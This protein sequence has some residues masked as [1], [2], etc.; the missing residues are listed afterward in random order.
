MK[1][2][3]K[4]SKKTITSLHC[5]LLLSLLAGTSPVLAQTASIQPIYAPGA[6]FSVTALNDHG[7]VAGY[8]FESESVQ[9]AFI[10]R[11]GLAADIGTLGGSFSLAR[12]LNNSGAVVGFSSLSSESVFR[13]FVTSGNQMFDA[14]SLGGTFSAAMAISDAGH[15]VGDSNVPEDGSVFRAFLV[16][17]SGSVVD[18]GTLGGSWST[19]V[20]VNSSGAVAGYSVLPGDTAMHAYLYNGQTTVDLGTLGGASS[21]AVDVN[22]TGQVA[23]NSTT[24]AESTHA[25]LFA[26]GDM[27]DLGTLGGSGSS[28]VGLNDS[29]WV[30]GNSTTTD[31]S[32]TRGFV[33]RDGAMTDLGSL[34]SGNSTARSLNN[35]GQIVGV[36]ADADGQGRAFLW[37]PGGMVDLNSFLPANSGWLLTSA[38]FINENQQVVGEGL[39]DGQ[40]SWYL[41][42]LT[43]G[44]QTNQPPVANAGPDQVL[45]CNGL[46]Q[47]DG[48]G[49]SDA[50]G[51]SLT[52]EW[53]E[54]GQSLGTGAE[55][56]LSLARG[57][58]VVTLRVTDAKGASSED[59]V[60]V[61]V[62]ADLLAP[63]IVCPGTTVVPGDVRGRGV[64]PDLLA[65]LVA[66]DNCTDANAFVKKQTPAAGTVMKGGRQTVVLTVSDASGNVATCQ[67]LVE[68]VDVTPPVVTCA[69]DDVFRRVSTNCSAVVPN[70]AG[71]V[72][73][74]DNI[75]PAGQLVVTQEP[76]QGTLV[77]PG[78]HEVRVTVTDRSGNSTVCKVRLLVADLTAPRVDDVSAGLSVLSPTDR[79]MVPVTISVTARDN[80]DP[81]PV[82]RIVS[83]TSSQPVTGPNDNTTPDWQVT[84][85][86]TLKLRAETSSPRSA[87]VYFILVAVSD[88]SGNTTY[89]SVWV[90]VP[91]S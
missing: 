4:N 78:T 14:G 86:L 73:A 61:R 40:P 87:R 6:P 80:C 36:S 16:T 35:R 90:R 57:E 27:V 10:W 72:R 18:L 32:A 68:V 62:E 9:R 21:Q 52:F 26:N 48:R 28:A 45:Q 70:I 2:L 65:G 82:A 33:Y 69:P 25:F 66:T 43:N 55:L 24:A 39:L 64:V 50:D 17:P 5:N 34:G 77:G 1:K 29:G 75:T 23:G 47:L 88:A 89:R 12:A 30:V 74:T 7:H 42:G 15:I 49:S 85:D 54:A 53:F 71:K 56:R 60:V 44:Q 67:V 20:A 58:H 31:D 8:F 51:D 19:A 81:N 59:G 83:V 38:A 84:G 22:G 79:R 91:R 3:T 13:A 76:A 63:V 37:Q 41:L 46:V 11:D